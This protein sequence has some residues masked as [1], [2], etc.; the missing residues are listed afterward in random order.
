MEQKVA[1]N[2]KRGNKCRNGIVHLDFAIMG[3]GTGMPADGMWLLN[4]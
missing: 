1:S 4:V 2:E 3:E